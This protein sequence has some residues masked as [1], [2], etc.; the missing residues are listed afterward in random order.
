MEPDQ[1][2][3]MEYFME[4]LG[5]QLTDIITNQVWQNIDDA[6]MHVV[7]KDRYKYNPFIITLN[8]ELVKSYGAV[9]VRGLFNS[10]KHLKDAISHFNDEK[11]EGLPGD[12]ITLVPERVLARLSPWFRPGEFYYRLS[13]PGNI[14]C[15]VNAVAVC[16]WL[17]K[18]EYH[19]IDQEL[20]ENY[21]IETVR[22]HLDDLF[23][24]EG[25]SL[26]KLWHGY[27]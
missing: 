3:Q 24:R 21:A 15:S 20:S 25:Y 16:K 12:G 2:F 18:T 27:E 14:T 5:L 4:E 10:D 8:E 9:R 6:F 17:I 19:F 22:S 7:L 11:L 23:K 1:F 13:W 26:K